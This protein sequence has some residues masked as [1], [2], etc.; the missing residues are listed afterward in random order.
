MLGSV[1]MRLCEVKYL[2]GPVGLLYSG[3][4]LFYIFN[5]QLNE[6]MYLILFMVFLKTRERKQ[7]G[8]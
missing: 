5:K 2:L 7:K 1:A 3:D 8:K 4:I 6:Q